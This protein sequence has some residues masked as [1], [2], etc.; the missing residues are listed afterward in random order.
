MAEQDHQGDGQPDEAGLLPAG[1][2]ID[3]PETASAPEAAAIAA[4][5]GAHLRDRERAAAEQDSDEEPAWP[6]EKWR[7]A[8]RIDAIQGRQVR[9]PD[10]TPRDAWSAAGRTERF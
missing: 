5:V 2:T 8:G 10:G 1:A 7:F 4:A 9:V 6:G 3:I